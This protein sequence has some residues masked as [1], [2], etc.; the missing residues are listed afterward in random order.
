VYLMR[1]PQLVQLVQLA[2]DD[3]SDMCCGEL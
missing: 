2:Q 3:M 1:N